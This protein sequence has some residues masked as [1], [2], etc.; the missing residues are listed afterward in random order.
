MAYFWN[1]AQPMV[2]TQYLFRQPESHHAN[3]VFTHT[4][5]NHPKHLWNHK[6]INNCCINILFF[7]W[8]LSPLI[9]LNTPKIRSNSQK[10]SP[11]S[12]QLRFSTTSPPQKKHPRS[13]LNAKRPKR[14]KR[15]T[16]QPLSLQAHEHM[17]QT[18][19]LPK[20]RCGGDIEPEMSRQVVVQFGQNFKVEMCFFKSM[21]W[22]PIYLASYLSTVS[23]CMS[24]YISNLVES[25]Y[26]SIY[27]SIP[28]SYLYTICMN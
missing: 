17:W 2:A 21:P 9:S 1:N 15:S 16:R 19:H 26:L 28:L 7:S 3:E 27:L 13:C 5:N 10:K 25:I 14:P 22:V 8:I 24:I 11:N 6:L 12:S 4:E 20:P 18:A 23:K